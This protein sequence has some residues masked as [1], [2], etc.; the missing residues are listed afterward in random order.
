MFTAFRLLNYIFW[1]DLYIFPVT[2]I[3]VLASLVTID[4]SPF[5]LVFRLYILG[6]ERVF[7]LLNSWVSLK[8]YK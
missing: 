5:F 7:S 2:Y 8:L 6:R 1:C 3:D 4:F